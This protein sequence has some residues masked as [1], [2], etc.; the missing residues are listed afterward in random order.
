MNCA[1]LSAGNFMKKVGLSNQKKPSARA[2]HSDGR[3]KAA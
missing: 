2:H 1:F 3:V